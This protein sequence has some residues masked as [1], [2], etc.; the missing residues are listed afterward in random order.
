VAPELTLVP[1]IGIAVV[2]AA[3]LAVV[4]TRL[5]QP[6]PSPTSGPDS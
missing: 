4:F 2:T 5:R 6:A 3:V 1:A